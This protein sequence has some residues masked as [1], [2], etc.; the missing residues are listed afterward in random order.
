MAC[1][2]LQKGRCLLYESRPVTCR[3]YGV[4]TASG[5]QAHTC[6]KAGFQQGGTYTTVD[7]D[8]VN[9][10]LNQLS[11]ALLEKWPQAPTRRMDLARVVQNAS[12]YGGE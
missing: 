7:L 5:G 1:P 2:L 11:S 8:A 10:A 3:L 6:H 12:A 9:Q 4:P